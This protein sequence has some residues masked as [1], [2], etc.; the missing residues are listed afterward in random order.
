MVHT[1]DGSRIVR[2]FIAQGSAKVRHRIEQFKVTFTDKS[3]GSEADSQGVE[4]PY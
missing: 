3:V 1:K 4:T 2:E